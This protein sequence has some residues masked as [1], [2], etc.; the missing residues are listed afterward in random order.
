MHLQACDPDF[1]IRG[2]TD[3]GTFWEKWQET[4][5]KLKNQRF[6]ENIVEGHGG[7]N[8]VFG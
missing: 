5:W 7:S 3:E 2:T 8:K 4:T 1:P 6:W